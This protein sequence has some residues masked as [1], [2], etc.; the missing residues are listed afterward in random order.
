MG[1]R[2]NYVVRKGNKQTIYYHK[3][4]GNSMTSD[5]Y[6][7]EKK[8]LDMVRECTVNEEL[9]DEVW[10][11]GCVLIDMDARHLYFWAL[12]FPNEST[13]IDYYVSKLAEKWPGWEVQQLANR[14]Y[15][16]EKVFSLNYLSWQK[17]D[18]PERVAADDIV[19]DFDEAWAEAL[20]VIKDEAGEFITKT[21]NITIEKIIDYGVNAVPLLKKRPAMA[22]PAEDDD[23]TFNTLII[24]TLAKKIMINQSIFS[25]W[26]SCGYQWPGYS[27][28]MGDYGYVRVLAMAGISS[29][30][31]KV[32][33]DEV[34]EEFESLIADHDAF[35]PK[36][37]LITSLKEVK[38]KPVKQD[39][40]QI[41]N[42][43]K[44][45]Q[46]LLQK[47]WGIFSGG[48]KVY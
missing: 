47:V 46:T 41:F 32:S 43:E 28:T 42:N 19:N 2:V 6:Q 21:A 7:G 5:L 39:L 23:V 24:D 36:N 22:L 9:L 14:M 17:Y 16:A 27:L 34:L 33:M 26:E 11:E 35:G 30:P 25:L 8:F 3:W 15:D 48:K 31:Q 44:P 37:R 40:Q 10:M 45:K 29:T 38:E 12:E 13:V 1:Q 20:V 18:E 4:G